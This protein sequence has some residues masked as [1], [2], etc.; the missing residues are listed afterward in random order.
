MPICWHW[1]HMQELP[2][3]DLIY[4]SSFDQRAIPWFLFWKLQMFLKQIQVLLVDIAIGYF[5]AKENI[6]QSG[7]LILR[8][9]L[10]KQNTFSV[11]VNSFT[12]QKNAKL[13]GLDHI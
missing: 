5:Y 13:V 12:N 10:L 6:F 7:S 3:F 11:S 1:S 9:L 2:G 4:K 8:I